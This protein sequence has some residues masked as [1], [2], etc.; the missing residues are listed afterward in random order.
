MYYYEDA[1]E[2]IVGTDISLP[3]CNCISGTS[4]WMWWKGIPD[5]LCILPVLQNCPQGS[6]PPWLDTLT[7]SG[8]WLPHILLTENSIKLYGEFQSGGY[9]I[10]FTEASLA[11]L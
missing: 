3:G 7:M 10:D 4:P 9:Q 6:K 1:S 8:W 5:I 2:N 11:C